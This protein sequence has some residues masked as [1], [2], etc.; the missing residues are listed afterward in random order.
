M[1]RTR[2]AT[3]RRAGTTAA[4]ASVVVPSSERISTVSPGKGRVE[5]RAVEPGT[6]APLGN[7][8]LARAEVEDVAEG[9]VVHRRSV[10]DG[11]REGEERDPALG[12]DR[13]VD[14]V[15]DDD[16]APSGAECPDAE[17]LRDER[18]VGA[19]RLEAAHDRVL[20]AVVDGG[21]VVAAL[22]GSQ[23]RLALEARR[24]PAEHVLDI[25]DRPAADGEPL[26][27][28][29]TGWSRRPDTSLG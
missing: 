14:R 12:V 29:S 6:G 19:E 4:I 28:G 7:P 18:Q 5:R 11:D 10:G 21:R 17:L 25:V 15:D 24:Q 1:T 20:R 22:T 23:H 26:R 9:D 3:P 2:W 16:R 13:A 8:L 27:H